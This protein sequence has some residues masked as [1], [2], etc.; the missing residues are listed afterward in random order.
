MKRRM[1][2]NNDTYVEYVF[3]AGGCGGD[4]GSADGGHDGIVDRNGFVSYSV[5]GNSSGG[6]VTGIVIVVVMWWWW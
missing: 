2:E 1:E 5:G 3:G 6:C 4:V